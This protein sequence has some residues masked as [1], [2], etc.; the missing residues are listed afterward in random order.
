[1]S[2]QPVPSNDYSF[3]TVMS[4]DQTTVSVRLDNGSRVTAQIFG[5]RPS[6]NGRVFLAFDKA[7]AKWACVSGDA[8]TATQ[9]SRPTF[10]SLSDTAN[11]YGD[12]GQFLMMV[13]SG[14]IG[15]GNPGQSTIL[16][17]LRSDIIDFDGTQGDIYMKH[18]RFINQPVRTVDSPGFTGLTVNGTN[19][20]DHHTRHTLGG[21]DA[22]IFAQ[23]SAPT[24]VAGVIWID[25]D[26][27]M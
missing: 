19:M 5:G 23:D 8:S 9:D 11:Q 26:E 27:E 1:M 13:S 22:F 18:D 25:T 24:L 20:L 21:G 7:K 4:V 17:M 3:G 12:I 2:E 15:F 6:V 14:R 10:I 16:P